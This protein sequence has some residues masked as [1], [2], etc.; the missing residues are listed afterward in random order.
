MKTMIGII[1]MIVFLLSLG[2]CTQM[3]ASYHSP[4]IVHKS[5]MNPLKP[6][7][8]STVKIRK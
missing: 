3:I 1:L 5:K 6:P 2:A 8:L 4:R 7:Y